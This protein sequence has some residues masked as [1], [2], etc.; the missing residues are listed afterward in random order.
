MYNANFKKNKAITLIALIVTIVILL[1]LAGITISQLTGNGLFTKTQTAKNEARKSQAV[2]KMNL[3]ITT[4]Q[5]GYYSENQELPGLQYLA[6]RLCEDDDM[7]YVLTKSNLRASKLEKINV[8]GV[9]SIYARLKE[10]PYEFE[11]NDSLQL[12]SIDGV[13]IATNS[14]NGSTGDLGYN[15]N[16]YD[17]WLTWLQIAGV[18]NIESYN[19]TDILSNQKLMSIVMN[20]EAALKYMEKSI[21]FLMPSICKSEVA[22]QELKK[23]SKAK[24]IVLKNSK[25]TNEIFKNRFNSELWA[26]VPELSSNSYSE[27]ELIYSGQYGTGYAYK[28]FNRSNNG[29]YD[30]WITPFQNGDTAYLGIHFYEPKK[31]YKLYFENR[32]FNSSDSNCRIKT[33][34]IQASNDGENWIDLTEINTREDE[35]NAMGKREEVDIPLNNVNAYSYY[36]I[37]ITGIF[38]N[39]AGVGEMQWYGY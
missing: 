8:S 19:N 9:T 24:E 37:Y 3:K 5:I 35:A 6:D 26:L 23:S 11:I 33:Y 22:M 38:T 28:A 32:S 39:Y 31:V 25:W 12:A 4:A 36:R 21:Y 30:G 29:E 17:V 15:P 18:E 27:G 1:V 34:K 2:E 7:Q 10:Y 14:G 16:M 13:S 20:N